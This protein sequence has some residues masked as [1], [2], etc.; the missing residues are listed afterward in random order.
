MISRF[1]HFVLLSLLAF[2]AI[3]YDYQNQQE[4]R[5]ENHETNE[6]MN[7]IYSSRNHQ[8]IQNLDQRFWE[9]YNKASDNLSDAGNKVNNTNTFT[10]Q[11]NMAAL[12]VNEQNQYNSLLNQERPL[13]QKWLA[14]RDEILNLINNARNAGQDVSNYETSLGNLLANAERIENQIADRPY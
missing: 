7:R 11:H 2:P 14:Q 5:H 1:F 8:G 3:A 13:I 10:F 9:L 6:E 12:N 4:A